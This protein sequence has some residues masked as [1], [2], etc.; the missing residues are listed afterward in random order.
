MQANLRSK[1]AAV[2]IL[3]VTVLVT[4]SQAEMSRAIY[5]EMQTKAPEFLEIEVL[6]VETAKVADEIVVDIEA[7]ITGVTRSKS[8]IKVGDVIHVHYAR[9]TK[10]LAGPSP[11]PILEKK[12]KYPAFLA[13]ASGKNYEPAAGG[14]SFEAIE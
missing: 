10:V 4:A 14:R 12:K 11:V 6:S 8:G 9:Q 3:L 5:K 7:K 13:R 1:C 2:S